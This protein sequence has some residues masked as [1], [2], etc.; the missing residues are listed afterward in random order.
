MRREKSAHWL[1]AGVMGLGTAACT[2]PDP[3]VEDPPQLAEGIYADLGEPRPNATAEELETFERGREVALRRFRPDEGFGQRFNASFC[4]TCHEKPVFGGSAGRYRNFQ[5][6]AQVLSD[7][8]Y[9][10]TGK[11]GVQLHY[12]LDAETYVPPDEETNLV[13]QRRPS[14]FFGTGLI[15]EINEDA[16][17]A[18]VDE[19]DSDGDGISGRANYDRGFV[20]RFGRKSQTVS[21]EG[22]I[23]GPLF[24]H[25]GMTSDPLS[26]ERKAQLPVPSA[27]GTAQHLGLDG[28]FTGLGEVKQAQAAA[29]DEPTLDDDGIPDPELAEDDLFDVVA[30][31]MLLAAPQFDLEPTDAARRGKALFSEASCDGC[32]VATL[33]S[34]R[35]LLPLYSDLLLHDMGQELADGIQMGLATGSEYRTQP[36]WGVAAVGPFLHDGRADTLDEAIRFHGGEAQGSAD[37]YLAMTEGEQL[38]VVAFLESLGGRG[39]KSDGLVPPDAVVPDVGEYGAPTT[40]LTGDELARFERGREA[41]DRDRA[42]SEGI[43]PRFNGD[44]CR[45]CHFDPVVGGAG[46]ADVDVTRHGIVN[47][48]TF[49]A[50]EMG[51]MLHRHAAATDERPPFDPTANVFDHRQTPSILGLGLIDRIPEATILAMEDPDDMNGDGISGRAH[52]LT[53]GRVGRLGW[54]AGVPNLKEFA[55]DAMLNEIGITLPEQADLT[56]GATTDDDEFPDPEISL[57]ELGDL[58]FFMEQLGPP[59]RSSENA[60]LEAQ[61]EALFSTV[62]CA[63]CHVPTLQTSDGVDVNLFSDL[64]LHDVAPAGTVGIVDG[65]D[66][67]NEFRTPPLWGISTTAPYMHDGLATDLEQAIL[68]HAGEATTSTSNYEALS[69]SEKDALLA[70]LMS[71]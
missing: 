55:R 22:F 52:V 64:L 46:P 21:I 17:L 23:R 12:S 30:F 49:T 41:F 56:F 13:A 1:I 50:P 26:N 48:D 68:V 54:K 16:I 62:G 60:T 4:A 8:S 37:A 25:L 43:G 35:G 39:Q 14:P 70:F 67:M 69:Q 47:G 32:H 28:Q 44:S 66:E 11:S 34:P 40:A 5:L 57:A 71:L 58:V 15:A 31:S 33:E 29:P 20:G 45:A 10:P 53:D 36:L 19:E 6:V 65:Q 42:L 3:P 51:T 63:S 38:D 27:L 18:N 61:G 7:G 24:N 9:Q 59:P 2:D